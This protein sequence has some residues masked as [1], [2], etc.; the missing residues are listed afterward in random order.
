[1]T[2]VSHPQDADFI[3]GPDR[4]NVIFL[5]LAFHA[6]NKSYLQSKLMTKAFLLLLV[7]VD[8]PMALQEVNI[9][10]FGHEMRLLASWS[11]EE[12][13]RILETLH[14]YGKAKA[15]QIVQGFSGKA[16]FEAKM[17]DVLTTIKGVNSTDAVNLLAKF[18]TLRG[19]AN[20]SLPELLEIHSIGD[21][22]AK[23]IFKCFNDTLQK[24]G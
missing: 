10:A 13:A 12:C 15:E 6:A 8:N 22:K 17:K 7:D 1:M 20:A 18:K 5:S 19:I 14:I 3:V 21:K 2:F 9:A 16:D 4:C 11:F 24:I 23:S